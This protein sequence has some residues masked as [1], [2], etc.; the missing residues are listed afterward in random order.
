MTSNR[1]IEMPLTPTEDSARV[2]D[3]LEQVV[4]EEAEYIQRHRHPR[5]D[6]HELQ[7]AFVGIAMSGGGIRSATTNLGILQALSRMGILPMV[8]YMSTV[9]GGGYIGSC[10]S[11]L[12]SWNR[13][14]SSDDQNKCGP[15]TFGPGDTP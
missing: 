12:L 2:P 5:R 3:R 4:R 1:P 14:A 8:D 15:F 6:L 11:S 13:N 9:S 7:R 10:L